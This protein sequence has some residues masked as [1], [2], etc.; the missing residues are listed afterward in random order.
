VLLLVTRLLLCWMHTWQWSRSTHHKHG[1]WDWVSR[2]AW[3]ENTRRLSSIFCLLPLP[4]TS[5]LSCF[6]FG[7]VDLLI[8]LD[9]PVT[10]VLSADCQAPPARCPCP[11]L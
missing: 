1:E 6:L 11:P 2:V 10:C 3:H 9:V 5:L 4:H 8:G 7:N